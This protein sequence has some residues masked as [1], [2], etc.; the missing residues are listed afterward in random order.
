[1]IQAEPGIVVPTCITGFGE[2]GP[3]G[4]FVPI[5]VSA[6]VCEGGSGDG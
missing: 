5:I 6:S 3:L 4:F 1:M 2:Y